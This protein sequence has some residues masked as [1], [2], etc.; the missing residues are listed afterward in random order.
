AALA[1]TVTNTATVAAP[2]EN[3][4]SDLS[5]N[6]ASDS[7]T[8]TAPLAADLS[9]N[10]TGTATVLQGGAVSYTL[11]VWNQ[12]PTPTTGATI[13]DTVPGN[14]TGVNWTCTASGLAVCG[15]ASGSGNAISFASGLLPVNT[16]T[17]AAGATNSAPTSGSYLTITVTGTAT[18]AG[19]LTN[20]ASITAPGGITDAFAGNNSSSQATT[21]TPVANL[22][23]TKS[24]GLTSAVAP[25]AS[26]YTIRVTNGGP[27]SV[28]GAV[29]TDPAVLGFAA[30][31][32][33]CSAA[34]GNTCTTA[35]LLTDLQGTGVVLPL[36]A[37][38]GFYE[39]SLGGTLTGTSVGSVANKASVA[40]PSG[41]TDP[42]TSNNN[43]TD[44]DAV[45]YNLVCSK[46]YAS[47]FGAAGTRNQ[48]YELSGS[49][50]TSVFTA[51][52]IV[53]GLA[54]SANGS[55]YYDDGTF[56][57]PPLFRYNG[58]AQTAPG[59][60]LPTLNVGEA[61]DA[62]GNVYYLD[63]TYNLRKAVAGG[64]GA[65]STVGALI[66]DTGDTIGPSLQY[67]DLTFDGNGRLEWYA[68][69]GGSGKSYLYAIDPATRRAKNFGNIGPDG[70]TGLAF[71][72]AGK[73]ITT[74]AGGA[75]VISVDL[76]ASTLTGTVVGTANP[77]VY[78]L[79]SCATP[80]LNAILDVQKSVRNVTKNT[81][82]AITTDPGDTLEYTITMTN[83]GN[84]PSTDAALTD[85][86]PVGT[87]YVAGST[88]L[89]GTAVADVAGAMPYVAGKEVFTAAQPSG[90]ILVTAVNAAVVKFQV[91]VNANTDPAGSAPGSINN[92]AS[93]NY[94][95]VSGGVSTTQT[96]VNPVTRAPV[97]PRLILNK[98]V[99][100]RANTADQFTVQIKTGAT[101]A[102]S[103]STSGTG[104]TATTA[105]QTLSAGTAYTLTEVM[106]AGS[107]ST[108]SVYST[109]VS[110]TNATTGATTTLPSGSG[111]SFT[112]TP[113]LGDVITCT[114][115]NSVALQPPVV[116]L[117]KLGRNVTKNTAFIAGT[118]SVGVL[119]KDVVEYCLVYS[120]TG[121]AA[122]NF[123]ITD[124]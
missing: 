11:K 110:C 99:V 70:A 93:V 29:L 115:T 116:T 15:T 3:T 51:P 89:N 30:S 102:F 13:A 119:P 74:G 65:A 75:S 96:A 50:L 2:A 94:P 14:L 84:F 103:G 109:S 108:L 111:Q 25:A 63:G 98:T 6:T 82:P 26:T 57:A 61:A 87:S 52:Q 79:G 23:I 22:S 122:P 38:G 123:K 40:A 121:G 33:T 97:S 59:Q 45:T 31:S 118:G 56:A 12:G 49:I 117:L 4:D 113:V 41:T 120:N 39:I 91:K 16:T 64:S 36:I 10:K 7:D 60:T 66:F 5:D 124:N 53:G 73:L 18:T 95:T 42:D 28:T 90:V 104:T 107:A 71:D 77:P 86:I 55:A 69:V 48:L 78:D 76:A 21:I 20:T 32:L 34:A 112:L 1:S 35:P 43:A 37:N 44:T 85:G 101:A 72:A 27:S 58:T 92:V 67:G 80:L 100:G 19:S 81:S 88:T 106:A 9:I 68:A 8:V 105:Q 62:A 114:L 46:V 54:I 17:G 24:D 83:T 47:S